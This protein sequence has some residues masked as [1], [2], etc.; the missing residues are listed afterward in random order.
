M[1][2]DLNVLQPSEQDPWLAYVLPASGEPCMALVTSLDSHSNMSLPISPDDER[3]LLEYWTAKGVEYSQAQACCMPTVSVRMAGI[4][5][6]QLTYPADRVWRCHGT[7]SLSPRS[8]FMAA[9]G[10]VLIS[11]DYSQVIFSSS[12]PPP[13]SLELQHAMC[14]EVVMCS[15]G[16]TASCGSLLTRSSSDCCAQ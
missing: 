16:G 14:S 4:T 13:L 8:A 6:R 10:C 9:K 1:L 2:S 11:T 12:S 3:T 15:S 7:T 5:H